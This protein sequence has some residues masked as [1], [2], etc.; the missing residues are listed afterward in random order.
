MMRCC[1]CAPIL[2]PNGDSRS[3]LPESVHAT[4]NTDN[5]HAQP[6]TPALMIERG[7][8]ERQLERAAAATHAA[9]IRFVI[10]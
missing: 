8:T 7:R 9:D 4:S 1:S 10:H 5:L 3:G 6:A 2:C